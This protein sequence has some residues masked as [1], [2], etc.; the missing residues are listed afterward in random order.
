MIEQDEIFGLSGVYSFELHVEVSEHH[1]QA[2]R[3]DDEHYA[4]EVDTFDYHNDPNAFVQHL[5]RYN[6]IKMFQRPDVPSEICVLVSEVPEDE[7]IN[8]PQ[9][10]YDYPKSIERL[11][12][13]VGVELTPEEFCENDDCNSCNGENCP[14]KDVRREEEEE[15]E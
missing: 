4:V 1:P 15:D 3:F 5:A 9:L 2:K 11:A 6:I 7:I 14:F 12:D 10:A 13:H 8:Y